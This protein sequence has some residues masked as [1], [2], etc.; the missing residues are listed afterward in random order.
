MNTPGRIHGVAGVGALAL[1]LVATGLAAQ[2]PSTD[3]GYLRLSPQG[4]LVKG[5]FVRVTDRELYDNQPSFLSDDV[6]L[7]TAM[8]GSEPATTEIM[9]Y[10][11]ST[12]E[13]R[14]LVDTPQSEYSPTEIPGRAAISLV[15]DYG[16]QKQQLWSFEL[17]GSGP[18]REGKNLLP[19]IN[20]I[21][22]HAWVDER[23]VLLF[24]LGQPP[25]LQLATVGS[26]PGRVLEQ[27]PGRALARIPGTRLMSF[28]HKVS[29]QEWWLCSVDVDSEPGQP[30]VERLI[31]M[32]EG[33]EDYVWS[34]DGSIWTA[35]GSELWRARPAEKRTW[36]RVADLADLGVQGMTRLAFDSAGR[37]LALVFSR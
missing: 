15:R 12:G 19:A 21:G 2:P 10:Q 17:A 14:T 7:Y 4:E 37:T 29:P 22:Y 32:P 28:V 16:E 36:Q 34:P 1:S 23:R 20:P 25:T 30:R 31:G 8:R 33:S 6:L 24:V 5:S 35:K 27:N 13:R 11:L 3:I 18:A 9:R 26:D